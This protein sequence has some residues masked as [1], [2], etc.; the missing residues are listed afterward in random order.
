MM[1]RRRTFACDMPSGAKWRMCGII[2]ACSSVV[3][4]SVQAWCFGAN[5]VGEAVYSVRAFCARKTC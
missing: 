1:R 3:F 4:G 2:A 5:I